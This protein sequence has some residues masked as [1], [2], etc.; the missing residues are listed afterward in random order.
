MCIRDR[1]WGEQ[2]RVFRMIPGLAEAEFLRF[3]VMHRNTFINSPVLLDARLFL[4]KQPQIY[5]AGQITGVE[6]YM[7]SAACG[8]AVGI[9]VARRLQQKEQVVWPPTTALGGLL[10]YITTPNPNFQPMNVT[11]GLMEG[12]GYKV[13]K[14][15]EKNE[16]LAKRSLEDLAAFMAKQGL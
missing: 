5:F 11:F 13:R 14:K 12:L 16:L 3:G 6:G 15:K 7:E 10:Q 8:L 2:K 1:T 4:K 9:N